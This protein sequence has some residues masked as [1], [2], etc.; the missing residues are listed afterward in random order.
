M[1]VSNILSK[2]QENNLDTNEEGD[3]KFDLGNLLAADS[4]PIDLKSFQEKS[5]E[6]LKELAQKNVQSL[7]GRIF[8]LPIEQ[9]DHS[10]VIATLPSRLS[11]PIP[12]EKHVPQP[13]PLTKWQEFALQKGIRPKNKKREQWV[14]DESEGV[15]K[16]SHGYKSATVDTDWIL[17]HK[18]SLEPGQDPFEAKLNAKKEKVEKQEK[19]QSA[20]RKAALK[21]TTSAVLPPTISLS[22]PHKTNVGELD[23]AIATIRKS[24]IS[25][26]KF[27]PT[28]RNEKVKKDRR[29]EGPVV[30]PGKEKERNTKVLERMLG[31]KEGT[32][33]MKKVVQKT[34]EDHKRKRS[35]AK[36][37]RLMGGKKRK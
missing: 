6:Y 9:A 3:L 21:K 37:A 15:E 10:G 2:A 18:L 1:D 25:L 7:I 35:E 28:L 30:Q 22:M 16:R 12:R 29:D 4:R 31:P 24:T 33:Q 34:I 8:Q 5:D 14:F 32:V 19:R 23:N 36:V 20:N 17:P 13:K 11:T 26:G 27:E